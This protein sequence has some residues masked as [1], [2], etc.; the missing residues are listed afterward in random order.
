MTAKGKFTGITASDIT[1]NNGVVEAKAVDDNSSAIRVTKS[2]TINGGTVTASGD[3]K[4]SI[5][6]YAMNNAVITISGG[7]VIATGSGKAIDGTVKNAI[8]G[9]GWTDVEGTQGKA[10][11]AISE[12]GQSLTYKKVQFPAHQHSFTYTAG[13]GDNANT[14]TAT[15][16]VEGCDLP[17]SKATLTIAAPTLTTY[18]QTG[19][20]IS[21]DAT[22]TDANGIQGEAKI[23]YQ[24]K[25][26]DATYDTATETAPTDAGSYKAGITLGE[27]TGAATASVEYTIAQATTSI[28]ANPTAG[29]ITYGQKLANSTLTGGTA[30]VAGSFAWKDSTVAPAVSDSQTTEYDVVFTPTDANYATATCKVKLTVNKADS[31]VT[32]APTAKT[33][34]Y[35]GSA[36]KLVNAGTASGGTMQYSVGGQ[37]YSTKIPSGTNAATYVVYYKVVGDANHSDTEPASVT[38]TITKAAAAVTTAP[39]AKT[40]SYTGSAQKLVNAGTASGGTMQYALGT[41]T[42][43]TGAYSATIPTATNAGTCYV[44][45]KVVGDAN[46][47]DS[48]AACVTVTIAKIIP[49]EGVDFTVEPLQLTYTGVRKELVRQTIL[50]DGL[51]IEYS[52]DDGASVETGLQAKKASGE[53]LISYRVIGNDIY[54]NLDWSDPMLATIRMYATFSYPDFVLPPFLTE[55]GEEAFAEDTS[56]TTMDVGNCA[57]IDAYAFR[58]CTNLKR[59]CLP[60]DCEIDDTAFDGCVALRAIFAPSGGTTAAWCASHDVNFVPISQNCPPGSRMNHC[61]K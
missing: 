8:A 39:T 9:T 27:G 54:E 61:R 30:S 50:T 47:T 58:D 21:A 32:K 44:W 15:C 60:L 25:T 24:K 43:A 4:D 1:I 55:I 59:I 49:V 35:T 22:V 45:Y 41:S 12:T 16:T 3:G 34:S 51:E 38:V 53:Y 11:V 52:F 19:E 23:Q 18:G 29:A 17:E 33:L 31:A 56:L 2:V 14:I 10:A 13:T 46:H 28:T 42:E 6:I 36:Q 5:G 20:G 26:G 40:L 37:S 48:E 7:K 57:I